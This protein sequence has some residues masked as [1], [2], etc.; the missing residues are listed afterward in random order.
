VASDQLKALFLQA[1]LRPKDLDEASWRYVC[2]PRDAE[3]DVPSESL[4]DVI[5]R[6]QDDNP[7]VPL[8]PGMP[9]PCLDDPFDPDPEEELD[10]PE[11]WFR[12]PADE[13]VE[14]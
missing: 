12:W 6:E 5:T 3:D 2:R 13:G 8:G 7:P 4:A 11:G 1:Q 14:A 9:I 10:R